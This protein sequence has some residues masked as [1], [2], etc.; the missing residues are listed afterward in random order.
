MA[1]LSIDYILTFTLAGIL[2]IKYVAFD[3]DADQS[4]PAQ[5]I[6]VSDSNGKVD[7]VA[8][9]KSSEETHQQEI[10]LVSTE[11]KS[12]ESEEMPQNSKNGKFKKLMFDC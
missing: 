6:P 5:V 12:V 7:D 10:S 4:M 8:H 9:I 3:R 1:T 11:S 2:A